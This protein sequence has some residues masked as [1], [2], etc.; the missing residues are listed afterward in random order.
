MPGGWRI[1]LEFPGAYTDG[2]SRIETVYLSHAE[3]RGKKP[4]EICAAI[5]AARDCVELED[6]KGQDVREVMANS[7]AKGKPEERGAI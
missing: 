6:L 1:T 5:C 2:S 7:R 3:V 4:E